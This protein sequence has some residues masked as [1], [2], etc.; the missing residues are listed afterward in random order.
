MKKSSSCSII[1]LNK[2]LSFVIVV[3]LLLGFFCCYF[4]RNVFILF[5]LSRNAFY[6]TES[7]AILPSDQSPETRSSTKEVSGEEESQ[8]GEESEETSEMEETDKENDNRNDIDD[9]YEH[10][11]GSS[12]EDH[13]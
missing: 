12:D 10:D 6:S 11:N 3:Q 13:F 2:S 7:L 1:T 9:I 5:V 4:A 8:S